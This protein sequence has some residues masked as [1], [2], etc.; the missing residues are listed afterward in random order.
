MDPHDKTPERVS[1]PES[2]STQLDKS[3]QD[4]TAWREITARHSCVGAAGSVVGQLGHPS[5]AEQ[6]LRRALSRV[7]AAMV[8]TVDDG[9]ECSTSGAAEALEELHVHVM[10]VERLRALSEE[11]IVRCCSSSTSPACLR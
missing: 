1:S 6:G 11:V 3:G 8:T 2:P 10:H 7:E 5:E 9:S 4:S